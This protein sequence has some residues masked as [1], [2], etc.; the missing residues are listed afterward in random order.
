MRPGVARRVDRILKAIERLDRVAEMGL[1][2]LM[3]RDLA[4]LLER[5]VEV[6][7]Q[8]LLDIGCY[9]VSV[10][11]WEPP[12]SYSE[13]GAVLARHGVLSR[14]EGELLAQLARLRNVIV[15]VYADI[16]YELLLEHARRLRSDARRLLSRLLGY[17]EEKG[18]DP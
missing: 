16:D 7:I 18:L 11:G 1:E 8:G 10:M 4:P 12:G 9:I 6:V 5:E 13:V 17:M 15:H 14:G 2:E 3:E